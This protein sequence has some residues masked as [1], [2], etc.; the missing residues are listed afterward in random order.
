MAAKWEDLRVPSLPGRP[1]LFRDVEGT[2]GRR[3]IPHAYPKR[4]GLDG[5]PRAVLTQQQINAILLGSDYIDR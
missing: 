3:A 5:R 1:F 4:G 2:G